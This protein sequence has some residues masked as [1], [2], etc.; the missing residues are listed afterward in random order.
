[1]SIIILLYSDALVH[2]SGKWLRVQMQSCRNAFLHSAVAASVEVPK[3]P[4][5]AALFSQCT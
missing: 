3:V 1:M 5:S 2:C 4:T